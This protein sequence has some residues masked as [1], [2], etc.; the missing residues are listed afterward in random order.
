MNLSIKITSIKS[1]STA[2]P[3]IV[4]LKTRQQFSAQIKQGDAKQITTAHRRGYS[5]QQ[6]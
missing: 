2:P 4:I 5:D 3:A 1:Y 6:H